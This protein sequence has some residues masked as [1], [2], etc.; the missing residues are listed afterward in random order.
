MSI[1]RYI[2]QSIYFKLKGVVELASHEALSLGLPMWLSGKESTCQ[3]RRLRRW[4]FDPCHAEKWL[5]SRILPTELPPTPITQCYDI[6][7]ETLCEL[8][9]I[10]TLKTLQVFG[11]VP[12]STLQLLKEAL[13]HLQINCSHFTTSPRPAFGNKENQEI[14]GTKSWLSLSLFSLNRERRQEAQL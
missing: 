9:E 3:S 11:I 7:P 4:G 12:V 10:P 6:M 5:L 13:P 14:R 1:S 8:G 2:L